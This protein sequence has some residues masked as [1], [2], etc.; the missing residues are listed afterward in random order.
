MPSE[1]D[2]FFKIP[3]LTL[4]CGNRRSNPGTGRET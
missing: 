2:S 4:E 1:I 3:N